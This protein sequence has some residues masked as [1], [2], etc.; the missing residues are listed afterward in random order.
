[1]YKVPKSVLERILNHLTQVEVTPTD[2]PEL[3]AENE[4]II[5]LI[6]DNYLA[7]KIS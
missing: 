2:S 6:N 4:A 7:V 1:M 3:A 5:N